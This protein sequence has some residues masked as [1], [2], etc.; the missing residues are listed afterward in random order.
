M[1][2][3][4]APLCIFGALA[5]CARDGATPAVVEAPRSGAAAR[6]EALETPLWFEDATAAAGLAGFRT[7]YGSAE[8]LWL[9]ES[10]GAG[11]A[12][13]DADQ[14]G[15]LDAYFANGG[16]I[17][18]LGEV[19]GSSD[20]G[21][22]ALFRNRGGLVFEDATAELG[23]GTPGY[24]M[25][26]F[27][28]DVDADGRT[29]LYLTAF[30]ANTL[31][32]AV[33]GGF[34][35]VT[36]RAGVGD[37]R[38]STGAAFLDHDRDGDLDL[39][40]ANYVAFDPKNPPRERQRLRGV[41][42][43]FGPRG[44]QGA[45]DTFYKNRGDGTFGDATEEVGVGSE[46]YG[47]QAV[48]FDYDGDGF[49]DVLVGNDSSPNCLWH[50]EGGVRFLDEA[51]TA[52][53]ALS[54][55]GMEQASMG[56]AV[57]DA[58]GD[59][60]FDLLVTNFSEDYHT[61][62]F[63]EDGGLFRDRSHSAGLVAPTLASLGWGVG[64]LDLDGDGANELVFSNGH[65]YPQVERFELATRY[66]Q[67]NQVFQ[68]QAGG[69][70]AEVTAQA[71][72]GFAVE[73]SSRGL[74]WGDLDADGD[75]DLLFSNLD[76]PPTLLRNDSRRRGTWISLELAG[77]GANREAVGARVRLHAGGRT[78]LFSA[79]SSSS[80]LS[81]ADRRIHAGLGACERVESVEVRWPSGAEQVFRDL[82][83]EAVVRLS[84]G[85]DGY[86][87]LGL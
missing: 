35:D 31:Y 11:V 83:V 67:R 45:R 5:A 32:R 2:R 68:R 78:Q 21:R 4:G 71:G 10:V 6:D 43:A 1:L 69:A 17:E 20:A 65:I 25:G 56:V 77:A 15:D 62:Y 12:L 41:E 9:V 84:E 29:D 30:G 73:E 63:G 27:G 59:G 66:R 14:D 19:P 16:P 58:D 38:W 61:L 64:I 34:E 81:T 48:A 26:A 70:F 86:E 75:L 42:V 55:S 49:V 7:S 54:T 33:P 50:N 40:V 8:K 37:P 53:V 76:A 51:Y 79:S 74:A 57:G 3:G 47:F 72:P 18:G 24:T 87:V 44:M 22:D 46:G 82:P 39:Y 36:A 28:S 60:R 23:L 80:F 85:R 52:G 13:F